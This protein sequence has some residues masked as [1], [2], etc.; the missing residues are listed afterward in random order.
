MKIKLYSIVMAMGIA[1]LFS[2]EK[3]PQKHA[4]N[5]AEHEGNQADRQ[6]DKAETHLDKGLDHASQAIEHAT[7]EEMNKAIAAIPVPTFENRIG[8]TE[9]AKKIGNHA[10]EFA[11]SDDFSNAGKYAD[12][13]KKDLDDMNKKVADGT[14]TEDEAKQITDYANQL[15]TA[16]G[17]TL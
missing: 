7:M 3:N 8:P 10:I 2:C 9:M 14:Y 13:I 1:M 12:K 5:V 16:I 15:A 17:L 11:N 4:E 6:A